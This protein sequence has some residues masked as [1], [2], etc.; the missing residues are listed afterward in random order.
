MAEVGQRQGRAKNREGRRT[1]ADAPAGKSENVLR[2]MK[3]ATGVGPQLQRALMTAAAAALAGGLAGAAKAVVDR[4]RRRSRGSEREEPDQGD[5][6]EPRDE[7]AVQDVDAASGKQET[8]PEGEQEPRSEGEQKGAEEEEQPDEEQGR[9][10]VAG[11]ASG[12]VA[13]IIARARQEV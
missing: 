9:S 7:S 6:A 11:A 3:D 5:G 1:H 10:E 4:G 2:E 13:E 12:E 8:A